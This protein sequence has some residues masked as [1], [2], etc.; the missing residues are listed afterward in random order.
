M[1]AFCKV[2]L[3]RKTKH[4]LQ[5][6]TSTLSPNCVC[7]KPAN[8]SENSLVCFRSIVPYRPLELILL[9]FC[10][11]FCAAEFLHLLFS[12]LWVSYPVWDIYNQKK[13]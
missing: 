7:S 10:F 12:A 4:H 5:T 2:N 9:S 13:S 6:L 3:N 11:Q 1:E 8:N